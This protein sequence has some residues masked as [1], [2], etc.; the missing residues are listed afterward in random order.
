MQTA[1]TNNLHIYSTDIS[2]APFD[3]ATV[4]INVQDIN[5]NSPIFTKTNFIAGKSSS[6]FIC[7]LNRPLSYF[8]VTLI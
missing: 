4:L 3:Q 6:L 7:S 8:L 1:E 5:D 2:S